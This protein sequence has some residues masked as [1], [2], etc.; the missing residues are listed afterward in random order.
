M[1]LRVLLF[2]IIAHLLNINCI[3]QDITLNKIVEYPTSGVYLEKDNICVQD[4]HLFA[5]SSD[6]LEIYE[7]EQDEQVQLIGRLPLRD[8][9]RTVAV[10]DEYAYVQAVSYFED[11]T[12]LYKIDISDINNSYIADS[13][14]T[15]DE[16]GFG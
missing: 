13:V 10:K 16:N 7:I 8:D 6:G 9:A 12:N 1:K 5:A 4:N 2:F 3:A 14:F 11:H 15:N